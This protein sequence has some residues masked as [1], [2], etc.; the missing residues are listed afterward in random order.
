MNVLHCNLIAGESTDSSVGDVSG[1]D[2]PSE[3]KARTGI[4]PDGATPS[5]S[6]PMYHRGTLSLVVTCVM[7]VGAMTSSRTVAV[8]VSV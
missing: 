3:P 6:I 5:G 8:T 1:A 7:M 4:E 2:S